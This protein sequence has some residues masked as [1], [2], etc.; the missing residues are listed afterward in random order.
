[1][2]VVV[3]AQAA[4]PGDPAVWALGT[5]AVTWLVWSGRFDLAPRARR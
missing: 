2:L 5:G 1:M 3:I 4:V